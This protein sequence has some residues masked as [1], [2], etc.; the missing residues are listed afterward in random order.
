M[1]PG[2]RN[3]PDTNAVVTGSRYQMI[4]VSAAATGSN[5]RITAASVALT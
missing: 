5:A 4:E 1:A 2:I 3:A